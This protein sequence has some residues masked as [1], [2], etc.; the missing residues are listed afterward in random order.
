M[1]V[2]DKVF[3]AL[4]AEDGRPDQLQIDATHLKAH[5]TASNVQKGM[6]TA[7]LAA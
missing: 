2:F 5:L 3:T 7:I 6:F 4:V 1:G